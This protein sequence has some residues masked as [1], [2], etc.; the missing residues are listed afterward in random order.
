MTNGRVLAVDHVRN[1]TPLR[2]EVETNEGNR[3]RVGDALAASE[4]HGVRP[5]LEE[6]LGL[7]KR[8]G[9]YGQKTVTDT[10]SGLHVGCV[11]ISIGVPSFDRV[12]TCSTRGSEPSAPRPN[13]PSLDLSNFTKPSRTRRAMRRR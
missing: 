9:I 8:L 2:G 12:L 7:F 5:D 13:W 11:Q 3:R 4:R 10:R 1:R 6:A